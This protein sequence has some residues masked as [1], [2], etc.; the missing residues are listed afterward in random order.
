MCGDGV[1]FYPQDTFKSTG[2]ELQLNYGD[3]M[4]KTQARGLIGRDTVNLGGLMLADQLFGAMNFTN[5]TIE[6]VGSSGIFG[7]GFPIN[8]YASL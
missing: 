2:M 3:S 6:V 5:T 8:R 1:P 7:L 4:T